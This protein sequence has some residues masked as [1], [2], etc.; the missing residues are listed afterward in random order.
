[1]WR[2]F[3]FP[4]VPVYKLSALFSWYQML[5]G[6]GRVL[7]T[8]EERLL[9]KKKL[10]CKALWSNGFEQIYFCLSTSDC[11][12]HH[13][14]S[15]KDIPWV[16]LSSFEFLS[17]LEFP[18]V[19]YSSLFLPISPLSYLELPWAPLSYLE[20][21]WAPLSSLELPCAPLSSLEL[22]G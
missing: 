22:P 14:Y 15:V 6:I 21:P 20:L 16:P 5:H 10:L 3:H 2:D 4:T 13:F 18:W 9:K 12:N 1:M 8:K 19:L 11:Y 7:Y 17:S